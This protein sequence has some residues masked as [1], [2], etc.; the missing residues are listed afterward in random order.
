[1][2][3]PS[4]TSGYGRWR[5]PTSPKLAVTTSSRDLIHVWHLNLASL[6]HDIS[7]VCDNSDVVLRF[8][9]KNFVS[10]LLLHSRQLSITAVLAHR[11]SLRARIVYLIV[12]TQLQQIRVGDLQ[13]Q[14]MSGSV[15]MAQHEEA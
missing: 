9:V 13:S 14:R 7:V 12:H 1:M 2:I 10:K 3:R 4:D 11:K 5:L 6:Q 15:A 8:A